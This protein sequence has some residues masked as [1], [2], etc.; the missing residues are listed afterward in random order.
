MDKFTKFFEETENMICW[1]QGQD[2]ITDDAKNILL[3]NL[4][5]IKAKL[6]EKQ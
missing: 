2:H 4:Y 5:K 3:D 6:E 1:A